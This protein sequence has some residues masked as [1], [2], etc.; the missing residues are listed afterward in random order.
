MEGGEGPPDLGEW[1]EE[2]G[3]AWEWR[4]GGE[5]RRG[6]HQCGFSTDLLSCGDGSSALPVLG[7]IL[8]DVE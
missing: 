6:G 5:E 4:G 8:L 7:C 2:M 3:R 1:E